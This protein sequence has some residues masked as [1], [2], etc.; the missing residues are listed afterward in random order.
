MLENILYALSD[1][2]LVFGIMVLCCNKLFGTP[3]HRF[4]FSF[5][6][7][8]VVISTVFAVL[9]YNRTVFNQYF[10]TSVATTLVFVLTCFMIFVWL[11]CTSKW[12]AINKEY[13]VI[14]FCVLALLL[15]FCL[16]L[17]VQTTHL[18]VLLI[19]CTVFVFLQYLLFTINR[20][21]EELYH[22]GG[23]YLFVSA[24]FLSL[25][26]VGVLYFGWDNLNYADVSGYL[27]QISENRRVIMMLGLICVLLYLL[28][29]APFHFW[30][31]DQ[32]SPLVLPVASYFA[33]IPILSLWFVFLKI[34]QTI[35]VNFKDAL[36]NIY[37]VFGILSMI[38]G[39]IGANSSHFIKKIFSSVSLYQTGVL[40][41]VLSNC[42][43]S[44]VSFCF[45]Y[46]EAYLLVLCGIYMCFYMI[47]IN[48]EYPNNLSLL[49]GLSSARPAVGAAM[50]FFVFVLM[51]LP[52][53]CLFLT[54][55]MMMMGEVRHA[56]IIYAV[57]ISMVAFVPVY[58]KIVQTIVFLPRE[59]NFDKVDFALYIGLLF[60]TALIVFLSIK[61]Q[62]FL[63]QETLLKG[64]L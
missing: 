1:I 42:K 2:S 27:M 18:G 29:A 20:H 35:F 24:L 15:L 4:C 33:L 53:F 21:N 8:I 46:M 58:L 60:Y 17:M 49:K 34:N 47:K 62:Y 39:I 56:F 12:Y 32:S 19:I 36:E 13:G 63:I 23:R 45:M 26:A 61:P 41:L 40:L 51:G 11:F 3:S 38:F 22:T 14:R 30:L 9:F 10:E 52:P 37:L 50:V 16:R 43:A 55:F 64:V 57:L 31:A 28:G 6:K 44:V 59:Q 48:G 5:S 25:F 54:E 7:T